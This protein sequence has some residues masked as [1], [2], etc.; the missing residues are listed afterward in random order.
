[1][2]GNIDNMLSTIKL[3]QT[4]MDYG[5]SKDMSKAW[6]KSIVLKPWDICQ[7]MLAGG[8]FTPASKATLNDK[9][10]LY[11]NDHE[12]SYLM[13]QEN[14]LRT[15]PLALNGKQYNKREQNL[16][17]LELVDQAEDLEEHRTHLRLDGADG[18]AVGPDNRSTYLLNAR[19]S[20]RQTAA[21]D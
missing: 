5:Q 13:I 6:E 4:S 2:A 18:D 7:K 1:M 16:K 9:I 19:D 11:F 12:F 8:L 10:E 17:A 20:G 15:K 21:D 14:Y 3:D